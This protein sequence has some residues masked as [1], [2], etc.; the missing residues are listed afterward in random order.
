M[1]VRPPQF[2]APSA[3][4]IDPL[5]AALQH[6]ILGEK[7]STL[8]RLQKKLE[9]ALSQ[10][11]AERAIWPADTIALERRLAEAR[12]ALW[13]VTIQRELCGLVRHAPY[14]DHMKVPMDV[15]LHMGPDIKK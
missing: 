15:R 12:E 7:A 4:F 13:F 10:L 2:Y 9:T 14:F 11:E 6:E 3:A 1:S 8:G 5:S